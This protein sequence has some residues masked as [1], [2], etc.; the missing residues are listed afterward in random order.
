MLPSEFGELSADL[1]AATGCRHYGTVWLI[2]DGGLIERIFLAGPDPYTEEVVD[3]DLRA[4]GYRLLR[5]YRSHHQ[6]LAE[7]ATYQFHERY[8]L[9]YF[10]RGE[11]PWAGVFYRDVHL[12]R[13]RGVWYR[14]LRR[15]SD[16]DAWNHPSISRDLAERLGGAIGVELLPEEALDR[17]SEHGRARLHRHWAR[18]DEWFRRRLALFGLQRAEIEAEIERLTATPPLWGSTLTEPAAV[19]VDEPFPLVG[20]MLGPPEQREVV[21]NRLV[22]ETPG[23]PVALTVKS[24][25]N[26]ITLEY[27]AV[28]PFCPEEGYLFDEADSDPVARGEK[29]R[30]G[31]WG[32]LEPDGFPVS[33]FRF[34]IVVEYEPAAADLVGHL[35]LEVAFPLGATLLGMPLPPPRRSRDV[36]FYDQFVPVGRPELAEVE[37]VAPGWVSIH[38]PPSPDL[39]KSVTAT[40]RHLPDRAL[41]SP[42]YID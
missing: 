20:M 42:D 36:L 12:D 30:S 8:R 4:R 24:W 7:V 21:V 31:I 38:V 6:L 17:I 14:L 25:P 10:T 28:T 23:G 15:E 19:R 40:F 22:L 27:Q 29:V 18:G 11:V 2:R 37:G 9:V 41:P 32:H 33:P 3:R 5:V 1:A 13:S 35:W 39:L 26:P 34:R 16:D